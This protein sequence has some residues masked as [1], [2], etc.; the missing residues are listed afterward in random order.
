MN[1]KK[2]DAKKTQNHEKDSTNKLAKMDKGWNLWSLRSLIFV[3]L[4]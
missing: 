3:F 2:N 4:F 1:K